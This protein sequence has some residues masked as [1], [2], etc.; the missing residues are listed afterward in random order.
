[1]ASFIIEGGHLLSGTITPQGAKNEALQVICAS[2]LTE[3]KVT[4]NNIPDIR[5][6]NNL[7]QLLRDIG[8]KVSSEGS[9]TYTFQADELKLDYLESDEFVKKCAALR[10]SVL[11][12]GPLL[13]R[14]GKA[15]ITKPGGDKIG[16]R[17]LDTHFLG[18][19]KLGAKFTRIPGRDVYEIAAKR[20]KGTYMLLDEASVTG[21]ANI[22]MAAV[23]AKGTTTIYNAACEP[24]LQQ[25][26]HLLNQM[27]ANISGIG[28]NL[29][30]IVGVER[31]HGAEHRILPDMIEVGSF[32]GMAA[33]CGDGIRIKNVSVKD[34]GIIPDAFRRLGVK[35]KVENDDLVIPRQKHYEIQSFIDGTIMTLA[36]APWPGL[37]PDLLSVLIVVATQARGSVLFHQKMF[38]SRLF[39][40]DKLIDM[41]AQIILCDPHRAVVVGHDRKITLRGGRMSS[42]DI[43]AGIALL[44]AAMSATGTSRIDNIEQIDRGYENI[45]SRLNALGAKITRSE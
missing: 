4:I 16:R 30:N 13:A 3:E 33:M 1:M 44:I 38:E 39:F 7:I 32:I 6:V 10:G 27:G 25:L 5:D 37:T 15:V 12:I 29:L 17:R 36:D 28:S 11:M 19:E 26:C 34:L 8:V 18:F 22:V 45:E 41:G 23:F 42:P 20:L 43:R 14:M 9:G 31:L 24:Y 35:I 2:L 40:V 21:T